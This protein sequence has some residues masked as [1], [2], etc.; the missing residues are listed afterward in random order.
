M[1]SR[2]I[3]RKLLVVWL[4]LTVA[5]T[6]SS[7]LATKGLDAFNWPDW[8]DAAVRITANTLDLGAAPGWGVAWVLGLG[9]RGVFIAIAAHATGWGA[10]CVLVALWVRWSRR[11]AR[12]SGVSVTTSVGQNPVLSRRA[13]V[14]RASC[15]AAAL[16][17]G[18]AGILSTAW[19]PWRL[20]V[21]QHRIV[22][23]GL[24]P[25]LE[26]LRIA[27]ITDTHLGRRV[28][29]WHVRRA[30]EL[31]ASRNPDIFLLGG[32]SVD[33]SVEHIEQS[34]ALF[35]P[36]AAAGKPVIGV[37]GNHDYYADAARTAA[38]MRSEGIAVLRNER[39]FIGTSRTVQQEESTGSLCV[40]GLDDLWEGRLDFDRALAGVGR[41]TPRLVV[42]HNPDAAELSG[43]G[44]HRVDLMLSG[45]TH[46]GQVR[47][48]L[49]GT[50][51]VPS[52]FGQ[53]YAHGMAQGPHFPVLI[54]AGV[55][56]TILPIRWGVRPEIVELSLHCAA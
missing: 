47:L 55:G 5:G 49:L 45:H 37:L 33:H 43:A 13:F 8:C 56:M 41:Q 6:L 38:A 23:R 20:A 12:P 35:H 1:D 32:D 54:S 50:P 9:T 26:G 17:A 11:A 28:P 34:I 31:A 25:S 7:R 15:G 3:R 44:A 22:V 14:G 27:F 29:A 24:H 46:G 18:G 40:A 48:P 53:K 10:W 30:A 2:R 39:L 19:E 51:I 16:S 42:S 4:L 36:L 52:K 21:V